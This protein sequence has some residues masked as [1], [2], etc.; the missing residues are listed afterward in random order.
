[1]RY[2]RW[3]WDEIGEKWVIYREKNDPKKLL[4]SHFTVEKQ[5]WL[6]DRNLGELW[7]LDHHITVVLAL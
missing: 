3:N 1:M 5:F 6:L 7:S 2:Q 4:E